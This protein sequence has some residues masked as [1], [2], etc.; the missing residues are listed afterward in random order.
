MIV[1]S[2]P[3]ISVL[4]PTIRKQGLELV[5]KALNKQTF[6][7]FEWLIGSSF[8][9]EIDEAIWVQDDFKDGLWSL[10]RIY[11]KLIKNSKADL[12]VSWQ[13]YT[14]ADSDVLEKFLFHFL[15]EPKTLVTGVGNKYHQ[16]YPLKDDLVWK[17]PRERNDIGTYYPIYFNDVEWNLCSVPKQALLDIGG[18]DEAADYLY[19]GMDGYGV[20]DRINDFGG[21]DFKINQTIK[22]YSLVHAR[23]DNWEKDNGIHGKYVLRK[24]ELIANKVWPVLKYI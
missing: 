14:F 11:N 6:Q 17:D 7:D 21:Y 15:T 3:I 18:F 12:I 5:K 8:D 19:L 2:K 23:Q 20:N 16:V 24:Q 4:T 10:N 13:D 1:E 9:P 22:S